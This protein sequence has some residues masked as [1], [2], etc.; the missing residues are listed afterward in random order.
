MG[1]NLLSTQSNKLYISQILTMFC[2]KSQLVDTEHG[3]KLPSQ[4][5]DM[6]TSRW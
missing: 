6:F 2:Y 5:I 4:V 3:H 1:D